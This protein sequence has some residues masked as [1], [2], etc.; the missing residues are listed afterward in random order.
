MADTEFY[1]GEADGR[2]EGSGRGSPEKNE[3]LRETGGF[4]CILGLL[5]T[6]MQ[7]LVRSWGSRPPALLESAT[8]K[9]QGNK[10]ATK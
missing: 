4:W 1:N 6:F 8:D 5:F 3:F 7:K 10:N 9:R 2:G